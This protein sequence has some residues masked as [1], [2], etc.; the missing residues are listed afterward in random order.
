[1][2][3]RDIFM[4]HSVLTCPAELM[5]HLELAKKYSKKCRTKY[6][7]ERHTLGCLAWLSCRLS[8]WRTWGFLL[9]HTVLTCLAELGAHLGYLSYF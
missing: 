5:A 9:P 4:T 8:C 2:W 3:V 6:Y 1:M 7:T